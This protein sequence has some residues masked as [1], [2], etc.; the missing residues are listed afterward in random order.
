[1]SVCSD[2]TCFGRKVLERRVARRLLLTNGTSL[3]GDDTCYMQYL[4]STLT[5]EIILLSVPSNLSESK[6]KRLTP[7]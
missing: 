4:S 5:L 1:M 3:G 2:E 6:D 7:V